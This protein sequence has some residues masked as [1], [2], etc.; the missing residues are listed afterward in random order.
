MHVFLV[1]SYGHRYPE[2][3]TSGLILI[4]LQT[5]VGLLLQCIVTGVIFAKMARPKGRSHTILFSDKAVICRRDG[6][7]CV[8]FRVGDLR[9]WIYISQT[10]RLN[11][12]FKLADRIGKCFP[13]E[14]NR[15]WISYRQRGDT[16]QENITRMSAAISPAFSSLETS[17]TTCLLYWHGYWRICDISLNF[18]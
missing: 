1:Y 8:L 4:M 11:F 17:L 12:N 9:R 2:R 3:C 16:K 10:W 13:S 5:S 7:Y 6:C 15:E 18:F 14:T